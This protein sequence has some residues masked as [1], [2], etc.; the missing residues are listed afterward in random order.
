MQLDKKM[1]ENIAD[2]T[3]VT[4]KN[5]ASV[6]KA[7]SVYYYIN[8]LGQSGPNYHIDIP[9]IGTALLKDV[10]ISTNG[11]KETYEPSAIFMKLSD[12]MKDVL[13]SAI[14]KDSNKQVE[15]LLKIQAMNAWDTI[16]SEEVTN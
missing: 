15:E 13:K 9:F 8:L 16:A 10:K 7:F 14:E 4:K 6:I 12:E 5:V 3:G 11:R 2:A 1:I